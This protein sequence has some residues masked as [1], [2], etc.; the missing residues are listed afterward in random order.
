MRAAAPAASTLSNLLLWTSSLRGGRRPTWQSHT[1]R[2]IEAAPA[3]KRLTMMPTLLILT[4]YLPM[5]CLPRASWRGLPRKRPLGASPCSGHSPCGSLKRSAPPE[6]VE[7]LG[8]FKPPS[9]SRSLCHSERSL[10]HS[11][12]SRGIYSNSHLPTPCFE[13]MFSYCL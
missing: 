2:M 9:Y 4:K 6:P 12:R 1:P 5:F 8:M 13:L 11:E 10:C 7:G 3:P